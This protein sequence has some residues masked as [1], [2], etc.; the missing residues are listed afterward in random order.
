MPGY[1]DTLM[2]YGKVKEILSVSPNYVAK[3]IYNIRKSNRNMVYIP[4]IWWF[5]IKLLKMIP[6][7]IFKRL[8][9]LVP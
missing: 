6:E 3:R 9:F 8:Y 5:I 4:R 7:L 2:S 1:V